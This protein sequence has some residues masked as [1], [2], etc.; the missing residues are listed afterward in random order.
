MR[1]FAIVLLMTAAS[2]SHAQNYE[3]SLG[4]VEGNL[5]G[6]AGTIRSKDAAP[7]CP[8]PWSVTLKRLRGGKQEGVEL[9]IIESGKLRATLIPTRGMGIQ[10]VELGDLSL[11]WRSPVKEIVHPSF[12]NLQARGGLGWLDG[13]TEMMCRCGLEN[14]GGPGPDRFINNNGDEATM[15]L[16]L[17]GKI[18]NIPCQEV[19]LL[20]E[21][22]APYRVTIRGVVAE[23][24]L[25]GP[26][27]ELATDFVIE[28]GVNGFQIRD[29]VTNRGTQPQEFQMLYHVN[30]GAP[31]LE[32]GATLLAP[33]DT[34][35]PMNAHAER[36]VK[37]WNSCLAPTSGY[38]EQVYLMRPKADGQGR[39]L[40]ALRNKAG[41]RAAS[42]RYSVKELPY[43]TLWKNTGAEADGYVTGIE[44]GTNYPNRRAIEREQGRVPK[45]A[46]GASRAMTLDFGLHV[47]SEEV[48]RVAGEIERLQGAA[49][50]VL[51]KATG[52]SAS[53]SS[54]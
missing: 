19:R 44:P 31:L 27:L 43:L 46:G 29:V 48:G 32:A 6:K 53:T 30:L 36:D 16:T 22:K 25:F 34:V 2:L 12:V 1:M 24:M 13:F 3:K 52:R 5:R 39:S 42:I 8:T 38:I 18:A 45:L 37:T 4:S 15:E 7:D 14:N 54:R 40:A 10:Q 9:I 50:P 41:D 49:G 51:E 33:V 21:T 23:R 35:T 20:A 17:H 11:G 26:K 47:G 28:P